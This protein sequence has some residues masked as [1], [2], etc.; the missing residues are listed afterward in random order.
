[1]ERLEKS[2]TPGPWKADLGNHEIESENDDTWRFHV[3]YFS[4][5]D[6]FDCEFRNQAL[7]VESKYHW[8]MDDAEFTAEARSFVPR[9]LEELRK[10]DRAIELAKKGIRCTCEIHRYHGS[11]GPCNGCVAL[12]QIEEVLK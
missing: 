12:Q 10:R 11:D 3:F 5:Q 4:D 6:R 8:A 2:A 7:T 1:M 9:A